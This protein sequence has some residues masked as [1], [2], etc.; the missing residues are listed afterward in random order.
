MGSALRLGQVSKGVADRHPQRLAGVSF[1]GLDIRSYDA[2]YIT[3]HGAARF[4]F[5]ICSILGRRCVSSMAKVGGGGLWGKGCEPLNA[6]LANCNG[7]NMHSERK[8][9]PQS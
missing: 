8:T 7:M 6:P 2:F 3:A 5:P 9:T 1:S 4:M